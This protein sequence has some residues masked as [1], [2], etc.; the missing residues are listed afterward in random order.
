MSAS[1]FPVLIDGQTIARRIQDLA[2]ELRVR[3]DGEPHFIAVLDGA[4]IFADKLLQALGREAGAYDSIQLA[5]YSGT[6][7]TGTVRI[8]KDL[9]QD[10]RGK[11]VVILEDIVDTGRTILALRKLLFERGARSVETLTLLSKPSRRVVE[12]PL[13]GV[14]FEVPDLFVIG[15][16]MDLDGKYRELPYVGVYQADEAERSAV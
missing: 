14:G 15:F 2:R 10:V 6:E 9:G 3:G 1:S 16:G 13:E 12:V 4:R 11:R 7:S 5:S 8:V